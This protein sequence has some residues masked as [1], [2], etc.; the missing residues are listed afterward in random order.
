MAEPTEFARRVA[1]LLVKVP[2]PPKAITWEHGTELLNELQAIARD[3]SAAHESGV[4]VDAPPKRHSL[5]GKCMTPHICAEDG[6]GCKPAGVKASDLTHNPALREELAKQAH[7][8]A[9]DGT[10]WA[11]L[12]PSQRDRWRIQ[13]TAGVKEVGHG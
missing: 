8:A 1:E 13:A 5:C 6:P 2:L 12:E 3:M 4:M 7:A 11:D 10:Q 9:G